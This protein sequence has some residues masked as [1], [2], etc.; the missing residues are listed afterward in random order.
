[1]KMSPLLFAL[2][3]AVIATGLLLL[4]KSKEN[5]E[6]NTNFGIKSFIMVFLTVYVV[7]AYMMSNNSASGQEIDIGEPPF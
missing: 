1:M 4:T 3:V 6:S 5:P 7:H 2:L